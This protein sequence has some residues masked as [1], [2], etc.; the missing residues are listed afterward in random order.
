MLLNLAAGSGQLSVI[1]SLLREV[2][3]L[4]LN[5]WAPPGRTAL[6]EA[7]IGGRAEVVKHLLDLGA[8]VNNAHR[9]S[10]MTCLHHAIA[11]GRKEVVE[12]LAKHEVCPSFAL[13]D[14]R[15]QLASIFVFQGTDFSKED[16][17]GYSP[18]HFAVEAGMVSQLL[19]LGAPHRQANRMVSK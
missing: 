13:T 14:A 9:T 7:A 17:R 10:G 6:D 18:M 3:H 19:A 16:G 4:D 12:I 8:D 1:R 11:R 5:A 2:P 15:L